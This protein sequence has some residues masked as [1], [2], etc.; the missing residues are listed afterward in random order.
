MGVT[1]NTRCSLRSTY[2]RRSGAL[3]LPAVKAEAFASLY[4]F[5]AQKTSAVCTYM[6]LRVLHPDCQSQPTSPDFDITSC[7]RFLEDKQWLTLD[8]PI[9]LIFL[10]C[11][12]CVTETAL[13]AAIA[14]KGCII[15]S[16]VFMDPMLCSN[17]IQKVQCLM[18]MTGVRN[19]F[20]TDHHAGILQHL[21]SLQSEGRK[22]LM[23]GVHAGLSFASAADAAD[24]SK[25]LTVCQGFAD[26]GVL[27]PEFANFH[28]VKGHPKTTVL[29]HPIE[30]DHCLWV[31]HCKWM[32]QAQ[33]G[34]HSCTTAPPNRMGME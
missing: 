34:A 28:Q 18:K 4:V 17:A 15:S 23:L 33:T 1:I 19:C 11:G 21:H 32:L 16:A 30:H 26:E 7:F 6:L 2:S 24:F 27:Q 8:Q 31:Y 12:S 3:K 29:Y 9:N 10:G 22:A 25:F 14:S 5:A 13:V 20:L